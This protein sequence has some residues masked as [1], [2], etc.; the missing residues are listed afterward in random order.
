MNGSKADEHIVISR[1]FLNLDLKSWLCDNQVIMN[2]NKF[3]STFLCHP[4]RMEQCFLNNMQSCLWKC[5]ILHIVALS[6]VE[7]HLH[8]RVHSNHARHIGVSFCNVQLVS[9]RRSSFWAFVR[10]GVSSGMYILSLNNLRCGYL[11]KVSS[12][13]PMVLLS[14]VGIFCELVSSWGFCMV[15]EDPWGTF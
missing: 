12:F 5:Y 4:L 2:N 9:H 10:L 7:V 8:E 6:V 1:C 15:D 14:L 3:L 13:A 11:V